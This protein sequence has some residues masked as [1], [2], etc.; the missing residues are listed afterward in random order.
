MFFEGLNDRDNRLIMFQNLV[1]LTFTNH[2]G[3]KYK[4]S[5]ILTVEILRDVNKIT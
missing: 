2:Q 3:Y 5:V 1:N 4:A